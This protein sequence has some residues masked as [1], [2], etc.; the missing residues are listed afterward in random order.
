MKKALSVFSLLCCFAA[1]S[2]S[3]KQRAA[4]LELTVKS[5]ARALRDADEMMLL[6]FVAP[7]K[8]KVFASNSS[9]LG[10]YKFSNVE[11]R[12]IFPDPKF[13]SALVS[14]NLEFFDQTGSELVETTR[15]YSWIFDETKKAW[16]LKEATPFGSR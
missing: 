10:A 6:G 8:Q 15:Q 2:C 13:E 5:Y 9:S 4:S 16:F 11:V 12:K 3:T 14:L 1:M 7:E